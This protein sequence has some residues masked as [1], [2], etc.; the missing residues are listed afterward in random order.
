MGNIVLAAATKS[1]SGNYL[2]LL[3][4]AVLFV[5]LYVV[6]IRPQRNKQRQAVQMQREVV[7]GQRVRTTAGI[8]GTITSVDDAD[9]VVEVAPGV[10][11]RMLRRAVMD[12]LSDDSP[13]GGDPSQPQAGFGEDQS[14]TTFG[15]GHQPG[16]F[17]D[18]SAEDW[19]SQDRNPQV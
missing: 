11:I 17:G 18:S 3:F 14:Q 2:P 9:V 13:G 8:Y 19:N 6:M 15:D 16:T 1:S 10:N 7:P 4:I 5:I 12:V